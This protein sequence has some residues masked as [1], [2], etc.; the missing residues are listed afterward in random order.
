MHAYT[1]SALSLCLAVLLIVATDTGGA[2]SDIAVIEDNFETVRYQPA[3]N[4]G[5]GVLWG[6]SVVSA[7]RFPGG[8]ELVIREVPLE[9]LGAPDGGKYSRG[10]FIGQSP[11]TTL[12]SRFGTTDL[13][14]VSGTVA[15][16][17]TRAQGED[18]NYTY[19]LVHIEEVFPCQRAEGFGFMRKGDP[20]GWVTV[21]G[22]FCTDTSGAVRFAP[23]DLGERQQ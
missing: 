5:R 1:R 10:W 2:H 22:P 7:S 11:D 18:G 15:C 6:G 21:A 17:L 16:A 3:A 12:A 20:P 19:P 9:W 8:S 14:V 23:E 13:L 4:Q